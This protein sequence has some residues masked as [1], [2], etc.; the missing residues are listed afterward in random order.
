MLYGIVSVLAKIGANNTYDYKMPIITR[1][2]FYNRIENID[3]IT[4]VLLK[5]GRT[6]GYDSIDLF[7]QEVCT[8][9][10]F[11]PFKIKEFDINTRGIDTME[12][13]IIH[14]FMGEYTENNNNHANFYPK[15]DDNA[16]L[17]G[18]TYLADGYSPAQATI[19]QTIYGQATHTLFQFAYL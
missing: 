14:A 2:D 8:F 15:T 19:G 17:M 7:F 18:Y 9:L 16:N 11:N 13:D 12:A 1:Q 4:H 5:E 3:T 10:G 6:E